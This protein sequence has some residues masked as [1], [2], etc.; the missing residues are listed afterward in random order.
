MNLLGKPHNLA[1]LG[2]SYWYTAGY[3]GIFDAMMPPYTFWHV[4]YETHCRLLPAHPTLFAFRARTFP[5]LSSYKASASKA[6]RQPMS[7]RHCLPYGGSAVGSYGLFDEVPCLGDKL[8]GR[9]RVQVQ[10]RD[11]LCVGIAI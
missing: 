9:E 4:V 7:L 8:L 1:S 2:R 3:T 11:K 6:H 5:T 10:T